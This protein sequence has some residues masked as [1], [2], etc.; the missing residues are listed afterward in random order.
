MLNYDDRTY[1]IQHV[2]EGRRIIGDEF[3]GHFTLHIFLCSA[4][5]ALSKGFM[6][7]LE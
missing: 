5:F 2:F 6:A 7:C 4:S 3:H 1:C